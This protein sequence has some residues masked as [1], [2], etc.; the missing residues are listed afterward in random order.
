M[1]AEFFNNKC[2]V[3]EE[4]ALDAKL[5]LTA[6]GLKCGSHCFLIEAKLTEDNA[7]RL[8]IFLEQ[9]NITGQISLIKFTRSV[10]AFY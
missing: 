3:I 5:V 9:S 7:S 6:S 10:S 1:Y 2:K 4:D 8:T